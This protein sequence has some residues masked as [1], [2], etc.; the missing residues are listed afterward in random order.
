MVKKP[1]RLPEFLEVVYSAEHWALLE[2]LRAKALQLMEALAKFNIEAITHGSIARGDVTEKSDVDVFIQY[3]PSS[4]LIE[5]ALEQAGIP[6][7]RRLIVQATPAYAMKGYIE[8]DQRTSVSFPLMSMRKIER[9]F[10]KFGGEITLDSL[11]TGKRVAGVDKCLML[12]EPTENGHRESGIV[13]REAHVA[14]M[15]RIS[16]ETVLDRVHALLRRDK[17]G[18]TGVFLEREL[19]EGETFELALKKMAEENP[20]VRRRLKMV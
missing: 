11:K 19:T 6:I 16:V 17:V 15:L 18:R 3:P 12:I 13:G 7:N 20:A 8:I 1:S 9:E 5:T 14:K 10:Y 4:F 2:R